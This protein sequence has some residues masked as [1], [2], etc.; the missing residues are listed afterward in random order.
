VLT[1]D[2][3]DRAEVDDLE[4]PLGQDAEVRLVAAVAGG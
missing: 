4:T 2:E 1:S 3:T